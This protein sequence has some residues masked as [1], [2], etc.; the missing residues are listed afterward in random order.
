VQIKI[1]I[2]MLT[3]KEIVYAFPI[4]VSRGLRLN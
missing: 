3:S 2:A 4:F 1:A